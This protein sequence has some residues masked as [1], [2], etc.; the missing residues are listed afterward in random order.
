MEDDKRV[1]ISI[2]MG[3]SC[4]A[5]GNLRTLELLRE[6]LKARGQEGTVAIKGVLCCGQCSHG[7]NLTIEGQAQE[8]IEPAALGALLDRYL[9][10][11]DG[12]PR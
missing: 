8:Q 1:H 12:A 7:P 5:R 6:R 11:G 10:P 3:S 2:C 9:G 4:F